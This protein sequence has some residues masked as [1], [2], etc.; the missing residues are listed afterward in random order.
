[1]PSDRTIKNTGQNPVLNISG[2][3]AGLS[4]L[5]LALYP[6]LSFPLVGNILVA[7]ALVYLV[8]LFFVRAF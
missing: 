4:L 6:F 2:K 8:L 1:M 3:L 7:V 5:L